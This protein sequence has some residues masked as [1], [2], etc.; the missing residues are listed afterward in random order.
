MFIYGEIM[1]L[2]KK[3]KLKWLIKDIKRCL[4]DMKKYEN[5]KSLY[6]DE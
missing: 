3:Q 5:T 2:T 6:K 1:K 4:S